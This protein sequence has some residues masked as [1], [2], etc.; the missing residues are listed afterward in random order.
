MK[1][2]GLTWYVPVGMH[3]HTGA[4]KQRPMR[5]TSSDTEADT[6][7]HTEPAR[8]S[9]GALAPHLAHAPPHPSA[10]TGRAPRWVRAV[11]GVPLAGKIAGAAV[12]V[13]LVMLGLILTLQVTG[14]R[15][16]DTMVLLVAGL[17]VTLIVNLVLVSVAL[18]PVAHLEA[19][20]R[21][22]LAGDLEARSRPSLL[23][24]RDIARLG[25]SINLL[26]DAL[27]SDRARMRRLAAEVIRAHDEERA[28]VARELHDSVA[29]GLAA[30]MLQLGAAA[31]AVPDPALRD[32]LLAIRAMTSGT[33]EELRALAQAVYPQ[34]LAELG[35]AAALSQLARQTRERCAVSID[36]AVDPDANIVSPDAAAVLYRVAQEA[37]ENACLHAGATSIRITLM[38][39]ADA[40]TLEV[41][42][43]GAGFDVAA[44]EAGAPSVGIFSMRERVALAEGRFEISSTPGRGTRVRATVPAPPSRETSRES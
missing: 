43:D 10:N 6:Q 22:V 24:D 2:C 41:V 34:M 33:M 15:E 29:Q 39:E 5:S 37:L 9:L 38:A 36:A 17:L 32:R 20:A 11:L 44:A 25:R 7:P 21:R 16:R 8:R 35:L 23:A 27:V 40:A 26:L 42:D 1:G 4:P 18:K 30:Q 28:H 31:Q 13:V 3:V 14:T 19:L 12:L